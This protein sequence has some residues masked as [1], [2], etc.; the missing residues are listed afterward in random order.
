MSQILEIDD[1]Q[2]DIFNK[3]ITQ[4]NGCF[5]QSYEWG[6]FKRS[7]DFWDVKRFILN[8][9]NE[10]KAGFSVFIR[11]IPYIHKT[12]IYIPRG[13]V[14]KEQNEILYKKIFDTI[15]DQGTINKAIFL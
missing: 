1:L 3:F 8:D 13:P 15:K 14:V 12:F 6:E 10:I 2:K 7:F 5:L 4:N 11:K 9:N